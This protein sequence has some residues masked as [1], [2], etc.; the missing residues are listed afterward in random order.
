[1]KPHEIQEKLGLTRIRDRN[2]YVQPAC[3]TAGDGLY[4]G[5]TWLT[6]NAKSWSRT[7]I[8]CADYIVHRTIVSFP[9]TSPV[10][11]YVHRGGTH[12]R[13]WWEG[14]HTHWLAQPATLGNPSLC[15]GSQ[16]PV[17]DSRWMYLW[18]EYLNVFI[19]RWCS[20]SVRNEMQHLSIQWLVITASGVALG[21]CTCASLLPWRPFDT[22]VVEDCWSVSLADNG[23]LICSR[24]SSVL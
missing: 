3:A 24:N 11:V 9:I 20:C 2:W 23:A 15:C 10:R 5:L 8:G 13:G 22:R 18:R 12:T 19:A 1:M 6:S 4:E 17:T 7:H 16:R 14:T 21:K